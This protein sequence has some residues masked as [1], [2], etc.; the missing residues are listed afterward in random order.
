[1]P[2]RAGPSRPLCAAS[3]LLQIQTLTDW[4]CLNPAAVQGVLVLNRGRTLSEEAVHLDPVPQRPGIVRD[5]IV[6]SS[7]ASE[8]T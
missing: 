1:M 7:A 6:S 8:E 5:R 2:G 3:Y 4:L